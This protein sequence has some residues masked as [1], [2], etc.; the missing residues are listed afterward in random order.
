MAVR[1]LDACCKHDLPFPVKPEQLKANKT[2]IGQFVHTCEQEGKKCVVVAT[3]LS[4]FD[5][6]SGDVTLIPIDLV[7]GIQI[8]GAPQ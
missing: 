5:G 8:Y 7:L 1:W 2:T 3:E 6:L 4:D